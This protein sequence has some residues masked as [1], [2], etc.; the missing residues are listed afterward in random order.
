MLHLY[1]KRKEP[2]EKV[3]ECQAVEKDTMGQGTSV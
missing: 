2:G 3:N 1:M